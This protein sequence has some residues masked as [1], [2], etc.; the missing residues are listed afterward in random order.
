MYS[1]MVLPVLGG[2]LVTA[3]NDTGRGGDGGELCGASPE[4]L[5]NLRTLNLGKKGRCWLVNSVPQCSSPLGSLGPPGHALAP[6]PATPL[7]SLQIYTI[8][9][10]TPHTGGTVVE[11]K[12]ISPGNTPRATEPGQGKENVTRETWLADKAGRSTQPY[13]GGLVVVSAE[14]SKSYYTV[15]PTK[16]CKYLLGRSLSADCIVPKEAYWMGNQRGG[17]GMGGFGN[18]DTL[19]SL[20]GSQGTITATFFLA[21][22]N[23]QPQEI[24]VW[25]VQSGQAA[26]KVPILYEES[27]S[28]S[29]RSL[30]PVVPNLCL[31]SP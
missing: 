9:S 27:E 24:C 29:R 30:K 7:S 17:E 15:N 12:S 20:I 18:G 22:T 28:R 19:A 6:C 2:S 31:N 23:Q 8:H 4:G 26:P 1:G 11:K 16:A 25:P 3:V 14:A 10:V 5:R 21:W 13:A